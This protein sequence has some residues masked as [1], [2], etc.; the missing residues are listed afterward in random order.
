M[1]CLSS[2]NTTNGDKGTNGTGNTTKQEVVEKSFKVVLLGKLFFSFQ[3]T[4]KNCS[5]RIL[6]HYNPL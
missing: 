1:G 3:K 4:E 2:K 5:F 6:L